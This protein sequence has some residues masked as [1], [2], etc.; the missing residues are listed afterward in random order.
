V[1]APVTS[2]DLRSILDR[3]AADAAT[4]ADL[5]ALRRVQL[6]GGEQEQR[7]GQ[8]PNRIERNRPSFSHQRLSSLSRGTTKPAATGRSRPGPGCPGSSPATTGHCLTPREWATGQAVQ[9]ALVN[10]PCA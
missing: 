6:I 10:A 4:E 9:G 7:Q 1:A 8:H 3:I 2:S 5:A